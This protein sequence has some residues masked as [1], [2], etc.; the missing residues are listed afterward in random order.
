[1]DLRH[2]TFWF[3]NDEM[4]PSEKIFKLGV[5][6]D[7]LLPTELFA[8]IPRLNINCDA[9]F[10]LNLIDNLQASSLACVRNIDQFSE[11]KLWFNFF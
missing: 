11:V 6:Y 7:F 5:I 10:S 3:F 2:S 8:A 1:M 4:F 9:L